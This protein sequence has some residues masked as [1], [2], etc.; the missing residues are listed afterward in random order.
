MGTRTPRDTSAPGDVDAFLA[1][2]DHPRKSEI[3][4]LRRL[5]LDADPAIGEGIKW[6]APSFR[7]SEFF[8][9]FHLRAREGVQVILHFGAKARASPVARAAVADPAGML[10]WLG[11]DRASVTFRGLDDVDARGA[12]FQDVVRAWIAQ[13]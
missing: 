3:L 12:A 11:P 5:V 6:N 8:A 10:A 1:A 7:T 2:L 13:M 9:T 4:A